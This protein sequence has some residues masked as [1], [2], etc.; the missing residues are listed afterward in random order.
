QRV[1]R[2]LRVP[3]R[4]IAR[5]TGIE[6]ESMR[7][8]V[9]KEL[10]LKPYK[11][12]TFQLLADR[13]KRVRLQRRRQPKRQATG[14]Q[15]AENIPSSQTKMFLRSSRPTIVKTTETGLQK[16]PA[17]QPLSNTAKICSPSWSQVGFL[18]AA[19]HHWFSWDK[20]SKST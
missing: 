19:R 7:Q 4:K 17:P 18:P 6:R 8:M 2:Y 1:K 15:W 12:E 9:K 14:M 16:P 20:E 10:K 5:K 11:P 3:T 13:N